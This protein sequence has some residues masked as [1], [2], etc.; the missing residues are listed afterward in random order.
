[1]RDVLGV[2]SQR[3]WNEIMRNRISEEMRS[4]VKMVLYVLAAQK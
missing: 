2:D 1:M 3:R 4:D